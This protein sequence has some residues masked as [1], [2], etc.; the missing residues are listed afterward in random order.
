MRCAL[1][2]VCMLCSCGLVWG[3]QLDTD[4]VIKIKKMEAAL[5]KSECHL[6]ELIAQQN[7]NL[8]DLE[9]A[10][11]QLLKESENIHKTPVV[12]CQT[13]KP[14]LW[15]LDY[16]R[17]PASPFPNYFKYTSV[18]GSNELEFHGWLQVD[19]DMFFDAKGLLLNNGVYYMP[20]D[21][22]NTVD[23]FWARRVRPTLEG[24]LY[25][26]INFFLNIDF[27]QGQVRLYDAF[28]D[29]N[30]LRLFGLQIGQQMSLLSG[31]EN[32]FD[33]FDYLSRA[34][35]MEMSNTAMLAPDREIGIVLHGSLG[36]Y[37]CEPYYRGLSYLGFDD[38]FSYQLGLFSGT[39]DNSS[40]GINPFIINRANTETAS[41]S[42]KA[43]EGRVFINPFIAKPY[44]LLKHLGIGFAASTERTNLEYT[45]PELFSLG[46]N[47]IF[48]YQPEVNANGLR[49]RIHPQ[50]VWS[51]G[52]I[53]IL[54]DWNQTL[55]TLQVGEQNYNFTPPSVIQKNHA[56]Q[57]Q[58]IYNLTQEEFNL[59]HLVPNCNFNLFERHAL[60]A[61]QLVLRY[62]GLSLDPSVFNDFTDNAN[63]L[64][65][66]SYADPR[67]S[68]QSSNSWSVG[69][70]WFWNQNIRFTTE[71]AETN[72]QGGCSTGGL[73]AAINPGCLTAGNAALATSSQV[74]NR[75][76]ELIFMQ[77][78][79][80]TF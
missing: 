55:Q 72:F 41:L 63:G 32:Y 9:L 30:Y 48:F 27:G 43:F 15:E 64:R 18:D 42:N 37:G 74:V 44:P 47:P 56:S 22:K 36:P 40:P 4:Q 1:K 76:A 28:V 16:P 24:T 73:G 29:I 79:Q 62:T 65:I 78:F 69:L 54:A 3:Q 21:N 68:V 60:G 59:F 17:Y 80:L 52:P 6:N 25:D 46:Q 61:W 11:A 51:L 2:I 23:R 35:T 57:I 31:I 58:M 67:L 53:G 33:N 26:Y 45:L 49:T 13:C 5:A 75:P 14:S 20:I 8:Q 12:V 70:N 71:F 7:Q 19:Q 39:P 34:Y 50:L 10:K 77:R 66:Y 38:F